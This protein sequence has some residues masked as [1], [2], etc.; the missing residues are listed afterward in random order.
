MFKSI[1]L[2]SIATLGYA[3]ANPAPVAAPA[4]DAAAATT[5]S[6]QI[7]AGATVFTVMRPSTYQSTI[8]PK[9]TSCPTTA[10][11]AGFAAADAAK[12]CGPG[13]AVANQ[14]M[15][16]DDDPWKCLPYATVSN[17]VDSSAVQTST[18]A[19]GSTV[20]V[21]L[22]VWGFEGTPVTVCTAAPTVPAK[23]GK[24]AK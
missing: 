24:K 13:C 1:T 9:A 12:V 21:N 10:G 14:G 3:A 23:K 16:E 18:C 20:S 2:L 8:V 15:G 17:W 19:P 5:F 7:T 22:G 6:T 4:P 11:A